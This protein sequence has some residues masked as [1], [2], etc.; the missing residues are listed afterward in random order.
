M[1]LKGLLLNYGLDR[2]F[3]RVQKGHLYDA[4]VSDL[5]ESVAVLFRRVRRYVYVYD[6]GIMDRF[7]SCV[8]AYSSRS[9]RVIV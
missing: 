5:A 1:L 9:V 6:E 2:E 8:V 4:L 7:L 3:W